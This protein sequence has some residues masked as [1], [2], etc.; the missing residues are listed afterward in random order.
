MDYQLLQI[1]FYK[2]HDIEI[3]QWMKMLSCDKYA[4]LDVLY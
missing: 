1:V 2:T 3:I 4:S